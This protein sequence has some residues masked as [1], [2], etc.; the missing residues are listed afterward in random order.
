MRWLIH[1]PVFQ[2]GE[3]KSPADIVMA[4]EI[5]QEGVLLRKAVYNIHLFFQKAD[6]TGGNA[7]PGCSMVVTL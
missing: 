1:A 7:V 4:A 2:S 6:I 3:I 5:I